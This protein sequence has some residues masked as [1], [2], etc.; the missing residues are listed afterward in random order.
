[1][2]LNFVWL[3]II[4]CSLAV[5][6]SNRVD[7][8]KLINDSYAK[9]EFSGV[10]LAAKDGKTIYE[11]T[12]GFANR[13]Y[14]IAN[15]ISTKFRICSVTKQFTAVLIMQLVKSGKIDLDNSISDYLPDFRKE[16]G[17]KVKIRE[18]LL[19]ASGFAT[20]PDEFYVSEDV[21][22]ADGELVLGKYLQGDLAFQPGARFNYNNGDFIILGAIVAKVSGKP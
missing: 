1:M 16:T 17:A 20:L 14:G 13:Q 18:L 8:D 6:A 22:S 4:A 12:V 9:G 19:S 7:L 10:I 3:V 21:Q 5:S 15:S 11:H 2:R